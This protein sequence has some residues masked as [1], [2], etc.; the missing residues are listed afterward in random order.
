MAILKDFVMV[1]AEEVPVELVDLVHYL[2][3][4]EF[5]VLRL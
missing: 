2:V 1:Q 3:Y 4:R 5:V